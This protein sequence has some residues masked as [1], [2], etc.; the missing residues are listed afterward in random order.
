ML[1][2]TPPEGVSREPEMLKDI[3]DR[4]LQKIG[5]HLSAHYFKI[6]TVWNEQVEEKIKQHARPISFHNQVVEIM[7]DSSVYYF[8][9]MNFHKQALL[10][11]LQYHCSEITISD[12]RFI[13]GGN[14][15]IF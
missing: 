9:L 12:I 3:L 5:L 1:P 7:V 4:Y 8:E 10:K 14:L 11:S 13:C 6:T 2:V 15:E